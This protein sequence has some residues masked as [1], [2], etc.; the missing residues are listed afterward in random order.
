VRRL[1]WLSF[2]VLGLVVMLG[3]IPP[4]R[5]EVVRPGRRVYL[6]LVP[7]DPSPTPTVTPTPPPSEWRQ[8]V[9]PARGWLSA[10]S[11]A[12]PDVLWV[13]GENGVILK[14]TD[15]GATWN[16]QS[17]VTD[18]HLQSVAAVSPRTAWAVSQPSFPNGGSVL[19]TDDGVTW[20]RASL[21]FTWTGSAGPQAVGFASATTGWLVGSESDGSALV[22]KTSDGGANWTRHSLA[23]PGHVSLERVVTVSEAVVWVQG[24]VPDTGAGIV[25]RTIDGGAT[26]AVRT[27]P[28]NPSARGMAALSASVA[29]VPGYSANLST[30][31]DGGL[32]WQTRA[33]PVDSGVAS[34]AAAM[35]DA[36][37]GWLVVGRPGGEGY[38]F[39]TRDGG[40]TW[41][42]SGTAIEWLHDTVALPPDAG[43]AVGGN[44]GHSTAPILLYAPPTASAT[45]TATPTSRATPPP[46]ATPTSTATPASSTFRTHDPA[47]PAP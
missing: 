47:R 1:I 34:G 42:Q 3:A 7:E 22:M 5:G 35:L 23:V 38:V 32:T 44:L 11:A 14:S 9:V 45:A 17:S 40:Q 31:D 21:P 13:V 20:S 27:P 10:I 18:A 8:V 19:R 29:W 15:G 6:Q 36:R 2:V 28:G 24:Y 30:T 25:L 12:S 46:T 37:H 41:Y 16:G 43:W 39:T 26:W 33:L 4:V